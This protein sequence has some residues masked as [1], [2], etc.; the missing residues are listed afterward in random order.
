M[1]DNA[2]LLPDK[3]PSVLEEVIRYYANEIEYLESISRTEYGDETLSFYKGFMIKLRRIQ[4]DCPKPE[5]VSDKAQ[6]FGGDAAPVAVDA[7]IVYSEKERDDMWEAFKR[8]QDTGK[9]MYETLFAVASVVV[10]S[11]NLLRGQD[12]VADM[13]ERLPKGFSV[14]HVNE[15]KWLISDV[16]NNMIYA[17]GDLPEALRAALEKIGGV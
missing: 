17:E 1:T 2:A 14:Y 16:L 5:R 3:A 15:R 7:P 4:A 12:S 6:R 11:R 13:M 9:G 8:A 10:R